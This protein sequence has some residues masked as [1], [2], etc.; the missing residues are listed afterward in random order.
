M[1]A[2]RPS[3][4]QRRTAFLGKEALPEASVDGDRDELLGVPEVTVLLD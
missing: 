3:S 4:G 1:A 2:S